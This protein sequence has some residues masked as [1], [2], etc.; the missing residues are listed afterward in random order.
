MEQHEILDFQKKFQFDSKYKIDKAIEAYKNIVS[1]DYNYIH[2]RFYELF[3]IYIIPFLYVKKK[4]L[5][6]LKLFRARPGDI[7]Q[8]ITKVS[9]FVSPSG[10]SLVRQVK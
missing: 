4:N 6:T 8:D 9:S 5:E 10:A 7:K 3:G 1:K 2:K